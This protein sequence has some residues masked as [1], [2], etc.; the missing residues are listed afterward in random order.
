MKHNYTTLAAILASGMIL[1]A[2]SDGDKKAAA[3]S[4]DASVIK[5]ASVGPLSGGLAAVAKDYR[6][7]ALLAVE[8]VNAAGGIE[9]GGKKHLVELVSEDDAG[10]PKQ[11]AVVAQKIVD[12]KG[13]SAVVGH[14]NSGIMI[15]TQPIFAKAS[16]I[17]LTVTTNPDVTAKAIKN[18]AGDTTIFRVVAP[19][20][21]QGPALAVYAQKQ[22]Y[23]KIAIIDDATA[24]GKGVADQVTKKA[25][26]LGMDIVYH[27]SATNTTTDFKGILTKIKAEGADAIMWGGLD[28]TAAVLAKQ[29]RELGLKST[30][31]MPDGVCIENY[32]KLTG[33]AGEGTICSLTALPLNEMPEGVAF[34][35]RFEKR[36][37]GQKVQGYAPYGYD[38]VLTIVDA[39]KKANSAEPLKVAAAM[40]DISSKVLSGTMAF[41]NATGERK[42]STVTIVQQ[43]GDVFVTVDKI[44]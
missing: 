31:L 8:E 34:K 2:C 21:K 22:G 32:M 20:T 19:D 33:A 11:G 41:D 18:D 4:G 17:A 27:D 35:E 3:A 1:A 12:D 40:K 23:K 15:V 25:R 16:L 26:E 10:D 44:K 30:L 9:I 43:K 36:F 13:I 5:I 29:T 28:D 6:D 14:Y 39:I 24:Y 38:S 37:T 42:D 7:G